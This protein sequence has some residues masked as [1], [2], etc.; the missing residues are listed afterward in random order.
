MQLLV[1]VLF[2]VIGFL[3]LIYQLWIE[4]FWWSAFGGIILLLLIVSFKLK[5]FSSWSFFKIFTDTEPTLKWSVFLLAFGRY[6]IFSH[7][8]YLLLVCFDVDLGY[9][10]I[11]AIITATYFISSLM[12]VLSLFDVF[13]KGGVAIVLFEF[14]GVEALRI[15]CVTTLMWLLNIVLPSLIGSVFLMSSKFDLSARLTPKK[16]PNV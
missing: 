6:L 13:L 3:I 14:F 9:P 12:P 15:L 7:Q 16:V 1:T 11:M 5:G 10:T 2:G 8:F 4:W